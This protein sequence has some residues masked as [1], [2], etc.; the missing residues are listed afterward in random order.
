MA[1]LKG[2]NFRVYKAGAVIA[3]ATSCVVTLGTN[4]QDV[5]TKDDVG[6]AAKPDIVSKNWQVQV[7]SLSITD[8]VTLLNAIKNSTQLDVSFDKTSGT[9]NATAEEAGY[10]R[11]GKAYITDITLNFNDREFSTKS[12]T[13]TGTGALAAAEEETE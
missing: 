12:V 9:G 13:F 5:A 2:Q 10:A 4:T 8:A 11:S 1:R 7:D 6:M 3:E